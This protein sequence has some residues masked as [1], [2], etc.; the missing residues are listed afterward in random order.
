MQKGDNENNNFRGSDHKLCCCAAVGGGTAHP[1]KADHFKH[2]LPEFWDRILGLSI[3]ESF[4]SA[5]GPYLHSPLSRA[6][7]H[8]VTLSLFDTMLVRQLGD[9]FYTPDTNRHTNA[10]G[11]LKSFSDYCHKW[12]GRRNRLKLVSLPLLPSD[13]SK[14]DHN[15]NEITG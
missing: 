2:F 12:R 13:S 6:L 4:K 1:P 3:L 10:R 15:Q 14:R 7:S 11:F 8:T 5:P 9:I